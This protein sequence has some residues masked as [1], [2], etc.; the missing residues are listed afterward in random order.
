MFLQVYKRSAWELFKSV[1]LAPFA[2]LAAYVIGSFFLDDLFLRAGLAAAVTLLSLFIAFF[3]DNIR[4]EVGADGRFRYYKRGRLKTEI[5]LTDCQIGYHRRSE[6]SFPAT[7][8]IT[9]Y[10][11]PPDGAERLSFDCAPLG[12]SRFTNLYERLTQFAQDEPEVLRAAP[13]D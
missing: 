2:G 8:S 12:V 7:H 10:I 11:T 4:C 1:I 3:S 13:K 9:L 5:N 6:G